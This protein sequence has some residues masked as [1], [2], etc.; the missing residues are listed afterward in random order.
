MFVERVVGVRS[1]WICR[2]RKDIWQPA[3]NDDIRSMTT[4]C[5]LS[6][7]CVNRAV[8]E[9]CDSTLNETALVERIRV[10]VYLKGDS[11]YWTDKRVKT[12]HI[13]EHRICLQHPK[14]S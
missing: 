10:D 2:R 1:S 7:V 8:S 4:A 14:R 11:S 5:S 3:D 6:V 12:E 9:C 13:P